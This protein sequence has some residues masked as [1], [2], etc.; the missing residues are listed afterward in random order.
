MEVRT[1]PNT[2]RPGTGLPPKRE[3]SRP[4]LPQHSRHCPVLEAGN[5]L[6]FMVYAPLEPKESLFVEFEGD[7]RYRFVY[8]LLTSDGK[9]T[10]IFQVTMA[11]SVGGIGMMKE[12]VTFVGA[13][14][15][16]REAALAVMRA[17]LVPEDMGTPAGAVA[18]RGATNFQ[19]PSGWDTVY[20][21]I[22]NMIERPVAPMLTIRVETDWYA[23]ETEFRYVLQAG[24]GITVEHSIPI[25]QVFF[26]PREEIT[27][28]DCTPEELEAIKES[29]RHFLQHKAQVSQQTSYGLTFSPYYL[30]QSREQKDKDAQAAQKPEPA[31]G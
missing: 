15:L 21:P 19:T 29:Q 5:M 22:L 18:L 23:H 27:M 14:M 24:E 31:K 16:S 26:V 4:L 25:G 8:Y 28:R 6:G 1:F 30:R 3:S 11:L 17:F 10:P 12:E 7:G 13:P 2:R 9:R 20:S